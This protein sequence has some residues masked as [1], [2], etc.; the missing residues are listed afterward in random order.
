MITKTG[1]SV[2]KVGPP[3][4]ALSFPERILEHFDPVMALALLIGLAA[5]VVWRAGN[6]RSQGAAWAKI[7]D[8]FA[9]SCLV[10]LANLVAAAIVVDT[11]GVP[12][13]YAI[14]VAMVIAA[15]GTDGMQWFAERYLPDRDRRKVD[16]FDG[17]DGTPLER[18]PGLDDLAERL[19]D[20]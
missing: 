7:R 17:R 10:G 20:K 1:A 19:D 15:K 14:G 2:A 11:L 4:I 8:D 16:T 9:V 12:P 5:G 3:A 13:L 18:N 6:Q